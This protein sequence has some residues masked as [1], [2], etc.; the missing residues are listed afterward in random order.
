M[1]S[2][3]NELLNFGVEFI[4][5]WRLRLMQRPTLLKLCSK[6]VRNLLENVQSR[7]ENF[8]KYVRTLYTTVNDGPR[9]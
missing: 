5:P 3:E 4:W 9:A 6:F 1:L 7:F 8:F 2:L